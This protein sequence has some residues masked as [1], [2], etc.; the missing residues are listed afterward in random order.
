MS[1]VDERAAGGH[2]FRI[3]FVC[4]GNTCRSPMAEVIARRRAEVLGWGHVEFRSAGVGAFEGSEASEGA[5]RTAAAHGLD[6]TRHTATPLLKDD[7]TRADLILAMSPSHLMRLVE[8]GA[9]ERA[10]LLTSYA[11]GHPDDPRE[12]AIPDPIGGPDEEYEQTFQLLER[13]ID[14]VLT[15]LEPVLAR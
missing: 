10:A 9:G 13:L 12:V 4:T 6:L 14:R 11:G 15:R 5:V 7:A 1:R 3:L 8:L 2:P